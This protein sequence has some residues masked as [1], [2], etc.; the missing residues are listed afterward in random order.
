MGVLTLIIAGTIGLQTF[1]NSRLFWGGEDNMAK[2]E[3]NLDTLSNAVTDKNTE[4]IRIQNELSKAQEE[5]ID[6]NRFATEYL[7]KI[8]ELETKLNNKI[9]EL[10]AKQSELNAKQNEVYTKNNEI[11]QKNNELTQKDISVRSGLPQ[12][13]VSR[14]EK[15]KGGT[16]DTVIRYL[17][18][19][20]YSL[21]IKKSRI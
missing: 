15:G 14:L 7:N 3:R 11:A 17:S 12:Q 4:I 21:T 5:A 1:A 2:I 8:S 9:T 19:M 18:S 16:L 13:S 6:N 10:N 20:G